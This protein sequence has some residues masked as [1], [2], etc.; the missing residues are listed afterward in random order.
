MTVRFIGPNSVTPVSQDQPALLTGLQQTAIQVPPISPLQPSSCQFLTLPLVIQLMPRQ[1]S[2]FRGS[3][4]FAIPNDRSLIG[5]KVYQQ[6]ASIYR[7][8]SPC[9]DR[10]IRVSDG[11]ELVIGL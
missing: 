3:V 10:M 9:V 7:R 11:L 4:T 8:C 1:G 2:A 5:V 6:F